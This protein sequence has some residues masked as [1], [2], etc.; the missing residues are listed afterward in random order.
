[1]ENMTKPFSTESIRKPFAFIFKSPGWQVKFLI[2]CGITLSAFIIP[3]LPMMILMGYGYQIMHRIINEDGE[4]AMPEWADWGKLLSDGW[5]MFCVTFLYSIPMYIVL[6]FGY[7]LYFGYIF[8]IFILAENS[9]ES[10]LLT[11]M[12]VFLVLFFAA[13]FLT[14]LLGIFTMIILPPALGRT[15]DEGSIKA[16]FEVSQWWKVLRANLGGYFIALVL[17]LGLFTILMLAFQLI[18]M[19]LVLWCL[20]PFVIVIGGGYLG[21]VTQALIAFVYREGKEVVKA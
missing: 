5:R 6:T 19:T 1:M 16:A 7:I 20:L 8:S 12:I 4:T 15:V 2:Y 3:V 10:L 18:Y 13:I 21:L 9:N 17:I 14:I 11:L